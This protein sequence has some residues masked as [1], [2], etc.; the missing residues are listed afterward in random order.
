M[1]GLPFK[2]VFGAA[3]IG[4]AEKYA[5][6]EDVQPLLD[7][8]DKEGITLIDTAQLYGQSETMLGKL[9]AGDK[10]GLDTKWFGGFK[11]GTATKD[12]IIRSAKDS[13]KALGV[14]NVDIFYI[15]APDTSIPFSETLDG[16]N[17]VYKLGLFKR[18]G[19]SNFTPPQ[20]QEVYD[21]CKSKDYP[22]PTV[23]Q[24]NYSAVARIPEDELFPLLR[25]LNITFYAYSPLAGGLLTKTP[26][27]IKDGAGRF[28]EGSIYYNLYHKP[29][30]MK[31]LEQWEQIA[32]DEGID[33]A[34]L[35]FRWTAW[36]SKIDHSGK[37]GDALIVGASRPEQ[38]GKT[39]AYLRNGPLSEKAV[40]AIDKVW[41][42]IKHEAPVD[43]FNK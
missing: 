5:S 43:N 31:A 38:V 12:N 33:R 34:E 16:I 22:L 29:A 35:G 30:Y 9:K 11:A 37:S 13:I 15:H 23:Y 32:K 28:N 21:Y 20:V 14:K 39:L 7:A 25:K 1:S 36:N 18:L 10:Y 27:D 41:E 4:N 2:V 40:K 17:E 42:G 24:G 8:L 19:I 26:Q 6:P 3:G